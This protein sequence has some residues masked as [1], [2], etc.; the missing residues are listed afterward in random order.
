[1]EGTP[2]LL[3]GINYGTYSFDENYLVTSKDNKTLMKIP[4]NKVTNSTV[5]NKQD[6]TLEM[7]AED[8]G[9]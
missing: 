1:M 7:Q 3:K 9:E 4:L 8:I 5:V 2:Q 6:V